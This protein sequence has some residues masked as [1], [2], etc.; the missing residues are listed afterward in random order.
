MSELC[1]WL[2]VNT[3]ACCSA[4]SGLARKLLLLMRFSGT[5]GKYG[6]AKAGQGLKWLGRTE[7]Y[8]P[9][10]GKRPVT[11]SAPC[12]PTRDAT[13]AIQQYLQHA[14]AARI[15]DERGACH[16]AAACCRLYALSRPSAAL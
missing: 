1:S 2:F 7:S 5:W 13:V 15:I 10:A 12:S 14:V 3:I 4:V 16:G 11:I 6:N 8:Q 9:D